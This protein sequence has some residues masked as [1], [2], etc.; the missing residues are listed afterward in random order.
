MAG[1]TM[2]RD[3]FDM[4]LQQNPI[5]GGCLF[6]SDLSVSE[7]LKAGVPLQTLPPKNNANTNPLLVKTGAPA[8]PK[9]NR[10]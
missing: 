9:E 8:E 4:L 6:N 7:K 5:K 2:Q 3:C 10:P 1:Y